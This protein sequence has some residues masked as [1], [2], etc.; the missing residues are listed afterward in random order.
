M[1]RFACV[2]TGKE[3]M[4]N[5]FLSFTLTC[6]PRRGNI[7]K[8][9]RR[10]HR[11]HAVGLSP[12]IFHSLFQTLNAIQCLPRKCRSERNLKGHTFFPSDGSALSLAWTSVSRM[13]L[14]QNLELFWNIFALDFNKQKGIKEICTLVVSKTAG[15][16][17]S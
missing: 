10:S 5:K 9:F 15:Y 14:E 4:L 12:S 7:S 17:C 3:I 11:P 2:L 13:T 6:M 16:L 1:K 8:T